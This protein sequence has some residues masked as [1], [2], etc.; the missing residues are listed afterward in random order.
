M[1]EGIA[2]HADDLVSATKE[3][4]KMNSAP[5]ELLTFRD[6]EPCLPVSTCP[7]CD[8]N[9]M[10]EAIARYDFQKTITG[11][12]EIPHKMPDRRK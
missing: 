6:N 1:A 3:A 11:I 10:K 9:R 8:E 4:I 5:L 7:V 12:K 2:V